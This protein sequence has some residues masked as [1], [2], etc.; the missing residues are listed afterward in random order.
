[1]MDKDGTVYAEATVN[2]MKMPME[3]VTDINFD[4]ELSKLH[5]GEVDISDED[6]AILIDRARRFSLPEGFNPV[7]AY[8]GDVNSQI[9]TFHCP[10]SWEKHNLTGCKHKKLNWINRSSGAEGVSTLNVSLKQ[11]TDSTLPALEWEVPPEVFNKSGTI[12]FSISLYDIVDGKLAFAWNT[13][14]FSGL[15]VGAS[16]REVG[17][18]NSDDIKARLTPARNEILTIDLERRN[19]V[20][21]QGYN[22]IIANYGEVGTSTVHF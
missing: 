10:S 5:D 13:P 17:Y 6:G 1:M 16:M 2:L 19:I 11:P 8:E 21:P 14:T 12:E 9:I 3:K 22:Y 20:A 18:K 7:I 15:S 4:E